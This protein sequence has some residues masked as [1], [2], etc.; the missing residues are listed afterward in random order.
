MGPA[1]VAA[2]ATW[3]GGLDGRF[4][5]RMAQNSRGD[6]RSGF[7]YQRPEPVVVFYPLP[8]GGQ[9]ARSSFFGRVV[10]TEP[11]TVAAC[12][13]GG[14][15]ADRRCALI[16]RARFVC[17]ADGSAGFQNVQFTSV[18]NCSRMV[19][20]F[21]GGAHLEIV[22]ATS[23]RSSDGVRDAPAFPCQGAGFSTDS[24]V[25]V[26]DFRVTFHNGSP[27]TIGQVPSPSRALADGRVQ[28]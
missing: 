16:R 22:G 2:G 15:P 11:L 21:A 6:G 14:L 12:L 9:R 19:V 7:Y 23:R 4:G 13:A 18:K 3:P 17:A 1:T 20:A 10:E 25:E 5:C 26:G 27:C 28:S 24:S 8:D